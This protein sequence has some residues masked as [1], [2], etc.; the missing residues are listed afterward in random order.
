MTINGS[1]FQ[2]GATLIFDPPSGS[3]LVRSPSFV[4]STQLTYQ[5]NPG[6]D[7]GAWTVTVQNPD[8]Q[9]AM[10]SFTVT[11]PSIPSSPPSLI[12]PG[13]ASS[14]G[15]L[16]GTSTPTFQWS[17]VTGATGYGLYIS[18]VT[19]GSPVLVYDNDFVANVTSL[20]LPAGF[21]QVGRSYRWN[22]R[23]RNSAGF[24]ATFSSYLFF[25]R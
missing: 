9:Q 4:N 3:N 14:P 24:S 2:G 8:G 23:A 19:T 17:A 16:I 7:P 22:M 12:T 1:G 25:R 20:A 5:F 18:D 21:L 15:T 10:R 6:S 13:S 11:A